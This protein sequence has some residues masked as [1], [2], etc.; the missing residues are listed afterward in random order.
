MTELLD[1]QFEQEINAAI[2][3]CARIYSRVSPDEKP[4]FRAGW[5]FC[6]VL[7]FNVR[8][9]VVAIQAN[10][11]LSSNQLRLKLD[12]KSLEDL[13]KAGDLIQ[14]MR[15]HGMKDKAI[16]NAADHATVLYVLRATYRFI[17]DRRTD[18]TQYELDQDKE[19]INEQTPL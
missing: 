12:G 9:F 19:N 2:Y 1:P 17:R 15:Q 6:H 10:A 16:K 18:L 4:D 14:I 7:L 11:S 8:E 3:A 5:E 13:H